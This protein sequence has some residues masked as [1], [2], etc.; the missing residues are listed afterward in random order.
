MRYEPKIIFAAVEEICG[1]IQPIAPINEAKIDVPPQGTPATDN[2]PDDCPKSFSYRELKKGAQSIM[3]LN[4]FNLNSLL[5]QQGFKNYPPIE[6]ARFLEFRFGTSELVGTFKVFYA[7][8]EG[9]FQEG[10]IC[11]SWNGNKL[12]VW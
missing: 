2:S 4:A 9:A 3:S 6:E 8:T 7:P 5:Q 12:K 10:Q 1:Q 11:A